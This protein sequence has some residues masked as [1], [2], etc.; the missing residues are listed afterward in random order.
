M[1]DL[2]T[3]YL[4]L[5]LKNP[6]VASASPISKKL[7][8]IKKLED[9]GASAV[10]M[11]SLFEEQIDAEQRAQAVVLFHALQAAKQAVKRKPITAAKLKVDLK[12]FITAAPL[13][14][15]SVP[16]AALAGLVAPM[17]SRLSATAFSPSSTCTTT[18]P[19][20]MKLTR[21]LK[22]GRSL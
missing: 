22:K 20:I 8:G 10:V 1:T 2:S 5:K 6:V 7:D 18:G 15:L 9:A 19:E 11:Y 3:S 4:G 12:E 21:S 13:A 16:A 17:I 14:S